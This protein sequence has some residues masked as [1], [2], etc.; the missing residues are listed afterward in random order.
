MRKMLLQKPVTYLTIYERRKCISTAE[1]VI[2]KR[3]HS[4]TMYQS[5]HNKILKAKIEKTVYAKQGNLRSLRCT[6]V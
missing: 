1:T 6:A 2:T 3:V 5:V 4:L